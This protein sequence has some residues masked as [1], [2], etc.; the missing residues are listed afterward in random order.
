MQKAFRIRTAVLPGGKVEIVRSDS[1]A[2]Q[3]VDMAVRHSSG[4]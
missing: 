4:A 1:E 2:G 3:T